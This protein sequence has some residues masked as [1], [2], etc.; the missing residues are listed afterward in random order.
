MILKNCSNIKFENITFGHKGKDPN[1]SLACDASVLALD[2]CK[3]VEI[4][5]CDLFGCGFVGLCAE[6]SSSITVKD[7]KIRDCEASAFWLNKCKKV[8]FINTEM[9]QNGADER[10]YRLGHITDSTDTLLSLCSI[11][12]NGGLSEQSGK[13]ASMFMGNAHD[14]VMDRCRLENNKY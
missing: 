3:N 9:Y 2:N 10:F 4:K 1:T 6:K 5:N 7:S 11:H 12:D 14:L 8:S 13:I